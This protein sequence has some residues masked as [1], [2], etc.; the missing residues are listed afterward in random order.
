MRKYKNKQALVL[1]A[2]FIESIP[3]KHWSFSMYFDK[4]PG[5]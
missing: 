3:E 2:D 4:S 5:C 1:M